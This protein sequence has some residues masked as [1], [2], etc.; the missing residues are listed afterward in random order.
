MG[1]GAAYDLWYESLTSETSL[2]LS[3]V[4]PPK[5]TAAVTLRMLT[6]IILMAVASS[7]A[8][9]Q[10]DNALALCVSLA[11]IDIKDTNYAYSDETHYEQYK[12][13]FKQTHLKDY[14]EYKNFAAKAGLDIPLTDGIIGFTG[15]AKNDS[16]VFQKE[17]DD[18]LNS[19]FQERKD[20]IQTV[21]NSSKLNSEI[22]KVIDN[23]STNYFAT[24]RNLVTMQVEIVPNDYSSFQVAIKANILPGLGKLRIT[25][26]EP[27]QL[28]SC[29]EG[30]VPFKLNVDRPANQALMTCTKKGNQNVSFQ[31]ASN[32]DISPAVNVPAAPKPGSPTPPSPTVVVNWQDSL[33]SVPTVVDGVCSCLQITPDINNKT[34]MVLNKCSGVTRL[35]VARDSNQNFVPFIPIAQRPGRQFAELTFPQNARAVLSSAPGVGLYVIPISCPGSGTTQ[36]TLRCLIDPGQLPAS[37]PASSCDVAGKSLGAGCTCPRFNPGP[38]GQPAVPAGTYDGHVAVFPNMPR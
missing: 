18:F 28:V 4:K 9:A 35:V 8:R 33:P 1:S 38:P 31:V 19:T 5:R 37:T 22:L 21:T 36:P 20:H 14:K 25:A 6:A 10:E 3:L 32:V 2:T 15:N 29:T 24:L 16:S 30:S 11:K 27:A 17:L 7:L 12:T 34:L 23:C 26:I 13:L